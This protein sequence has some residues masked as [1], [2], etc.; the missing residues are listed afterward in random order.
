MLFRCVYFLTRRFQFKVSWISV[1]WKRSHLQIK[2]KVI[3]IGFFNEEM[4]DTHPHLA[5]IAL[6]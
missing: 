2:I 6:Y 5:H 3:D 4:T 1:L